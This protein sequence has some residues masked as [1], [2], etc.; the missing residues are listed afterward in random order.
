M[1]RGPNRGV[2]HAYH[3]NVSTCIVNSIQ[4]SAAISTF[5]N[6]G[7]LNYRTYEAF[8]EL[9]RTKKSVVFYQYFQTP[10]LCKQFF[11]C[12]YVR[13]WFFFWNPILGKSPACKDSTFGRESPN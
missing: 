6:I 7:G 10:V 4:Q 8:V 2:W 3:T 13:R 11:G 12:Q 5:A 9:R 1:F